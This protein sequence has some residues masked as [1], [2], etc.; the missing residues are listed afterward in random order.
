M[1][2]RAKHGTRR[3]FCEECQQLYDY[4]VA[5]LNTCPFGKDKPTCVKCPVHCYQAL[6]REKIS[7]VMRYAGPR[8]IYR[9]PI[10][11]LFHYID[12]SRKHAEAVNNRLKQFKKQ[13]AEQKK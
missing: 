4:T 5:R 2:C 9:H 6:M 10:L 13:S 11:T 7:E 8:M 3:G 1:Y 12:G